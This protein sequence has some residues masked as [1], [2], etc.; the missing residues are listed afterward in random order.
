[1]RGAL[2]V[3]R[4]ATDAGHALLTSSWLNSNPLRECHARVRHLRDKAIAHHVAAESSQVGTVAF[5]LSM[6]GQ[7]AT[8]REIHVQLDTEIH[9]PG[10]METLEQ[11]ARTLCG[12]LGAHIDERR[13]SLFALA[14]QNAPDLVRALKEGTAWQVPSPGDC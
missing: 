12:R 1:M 4:A 14:T 10:L 9:D 5:S 6:M 2:P 3:G 8:L 7:D 13:R 11:L